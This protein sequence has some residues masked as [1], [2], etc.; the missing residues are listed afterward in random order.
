MVSCSKA[1]AAGTH[2]IHGTEILTDTLE[3]A[4][5]F[6]P[7][8]HYVF[9]LGA[10]NYLVT[11][12]QKLWSVGN[13][14]SVSHRSRREPSYSCCREKSE[15]CPAR[16]QQQNLILKWAKGLFPLSC[17][18]TLIFKWQTEM[19]NYVSCRDVFLTCPDCTG[20]D[21]YTVALVTVEGFN[22]AG[23]SADKQNHNFVLIAAFINLFKSSREAPRRLDEA[24]VGLQPGEV[25]ALAGGT[26]FTQ[27]EEQQRCW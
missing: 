6:L 25:S 5:L 19:C 4:T 24:G 13:L 16:H 27:T 23:S 17:S 18:Q 22:Q 21:N 26:K 10:F 14:I 11:H 9:M 12:W 2:L 15:M 7:Q 20:G 3:E 8:I 1:S